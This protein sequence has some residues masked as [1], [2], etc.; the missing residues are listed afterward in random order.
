MIQYAWYNFKQN[1]I[2]DELNDKFSIL[3]TNDA[4]TLE[5]VW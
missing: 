4:H 1:F 5:Y 3:V 2:F